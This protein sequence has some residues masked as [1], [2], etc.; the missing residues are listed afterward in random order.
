MAKFCVFSTVGTFPRKN[1]S[2]LALK[3]QNIPFKYAKL[4]INIWTAQ[5]LFFVQ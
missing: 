5:P 3:P 2:H 1:R 4:R